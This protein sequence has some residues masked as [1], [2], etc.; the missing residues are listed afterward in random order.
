MTAE[1]LSLIG[2]SIAM[3]ITPGPNNVM[4]AAAAANHGIG[5]TIPHMAGIV[6]GFSAM[7]VIVCAGLGSAFLAF[8]ALLA[9]F[10]LGGAAWLAWLAWQIATAPPPGETG[11][12][13]VLGFVGAM[14]FQWVNPKAWLIGLGT[15]AEFMAADQAL[16]PQVMR[17]AAVFLLVGLPCV[18]PWAFLGR[19]AR[20][21]L[22][23][24]LRLRAFNIAMGVLLVASL[25]PVLAEGW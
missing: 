13:R 12:G 9:A 25:V 22:T 15:A 24:P 20:L 17:I 11:S 6:V 8:P 3:Y 7:L 5:P 14:A 18:L 4:V 23:S 10:R 2:F 16:A 19:G 21:L 1:L